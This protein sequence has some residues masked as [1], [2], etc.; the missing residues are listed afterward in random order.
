MAGI[1][2]LSKSIRIW[3]LQDGKRQRETLALKPTPEHIKHAEQLAQLIQLEVDTGR[4]DISRHFPKSKTL[5]INHFGHY[6]DL[7][8]QKNK[9]TVAPSSWDSY[10]SHIENHIRPY[11]CDLEPE[12]ITAEVIEQ[13]LDERLYPR[14]ANKTIREIMTRFRKIWQLWARQ[15][16]STMN[17][18][19]S[20]ISIRLPDQ[21]DIDP[22]I[23]AEIDTI[24]S[25]PTQPELNNLWTCLIWSGLSMHELNALA[26]QDI[27][28]KQNIIH[29]SRS[30]VRGVY[31]VTKTR[32]RKRSVQ[33]LASTAQALARQIARVQHQPLHTIDVLDRDHRTIRK[34]RVQWLWWDESWGS[35][36]NSDM[37]RIRWRNHLEQC[38][39]RYRGPNNGR[40]TY[41]SQLLS[42]GV[43][44]AEW[45]AQ[46]LG[47]GST[48]MI[49]KHYGKFIRSD[50]PDHI[51]K[52]NQQLVLK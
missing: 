4:F 1:E 27:D 26:I 51:E 16:N 41:A 8:I 10:I 47:H 19:S 20:T 34:Q 39:I 14:L 17:D 29:V 12:L 49:H 11:F 18:P 52:L 35:H 31:R 21:E 46:Q 30:C 50:T 28:L 5:V 9:S 38:A 32:R 25:H 33:M 22:F 36:L 15:Y 44:T 43:I 23:R 13:W 48:Q 24:L 37:I 2:T 40:H 3:W 45:L 7:W 6:I 42:S